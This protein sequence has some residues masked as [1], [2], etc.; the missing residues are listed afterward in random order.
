MNPINAAELHEI[1]KPL[2]REEWPEGMGYWTEW[3]PGA[4]FFYFKP[5]GKGTKWRD[6]EP[7]DAYRIFVGHLAEKLV[8]RTGDP[9]SPTLMEE[10]KMTVEYEGE[11]I[12]VAVDGG[13][14]NWYH[15][16]TLLHAL[17]AYFTK[18]GTDAN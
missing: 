2:P 7:C 1:V 9:A 3:T 13:G 11:P 5:D 14:C 16:P 17:V 18:G 4:P 8:A 10:V 6:L 12:S 15:G